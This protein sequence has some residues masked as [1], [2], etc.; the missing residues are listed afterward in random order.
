MLQLLV[1]RGSFVEGED[2]ARVWDM[3]WPGLNELMGLLEIQ[4]L[5]RD[6]LCRRL[7]VDMA[8]TGHALNLLRLMDFLDRLLDSV[9]LF[10][11]KHREISRSFTGRYVEDRGD[12][13]LREMKQD[14]ANGRSLIQ[15]PKRTACVLV[16]I[17]EPISFAETSRFRDQL[18]QLEI[19]FRGIVVDQVIAENTQGSDRLL[20]QQQLLQK[21]LSLGASPDTFVVRSPQLSA[22]PLGNHAIDQLFAQLLPVTEN[23][24][25]PGSS[26]PLLSRVCF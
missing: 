26:Q 14:L 8:P 5:F 10:Q 17:A 2:L 25:T 1:E 18:K 15:D 7:V 12:D 4:R 24:L 13:F 6:Q 20:E 11:E 19:P 22:P 9:E 16:A 3:S 21:F 23:N